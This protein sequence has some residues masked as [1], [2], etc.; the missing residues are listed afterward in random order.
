[1][2]QHA[3]T[4]GL[5]GKPGANVK[6]APFLPPKLSNG[7]PEG[8]YPA[9]MR[10][11]ELDSP[12]APKSS[13]VQSMQIHN[14]RIVAVWGALALACLLAGCSRMKY[15]MAADKE[16]TYLVNQKSND[17]RWDLSS[18]TIGM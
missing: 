10:D 3:L 2:R 9:G 6:V 14:R 5:S 13:N 8:S 4:T 7:V 17:E 12:M 16:V 1:M 11:P 18:Y 15:R